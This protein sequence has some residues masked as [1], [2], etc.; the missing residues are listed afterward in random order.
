[1]DGGCINLWFKYSF[2]KIDQQLLSNFAEY[3]AT[4]STAYSIRF[5]NVEIKSRVEKKQIID[6]IGYLP[7]FEVLI[8]G[9]ADVIFLTA[10]SILMEYDGYLRVNHGAKEE[11]MKTLKGVSHYIKTYKDEYSLLDWEFIANYFNRFDHL[12]DNHNFS[13]QRFKNLQYYN[14]NNRNFFA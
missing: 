10:Q 13:L 1:M 2:K 6:T 7:T 14:K 5:K 12:E 11:E 3:V 9:F 4:K 8:C